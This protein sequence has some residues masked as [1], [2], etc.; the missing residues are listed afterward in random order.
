[1][2]IHLTLYSTLRDLLPRENKGRVI[3]DLPSGSPL[4]ILRQRL[5]LPQNVVFAVNGLIE[6]DET[7]ALQ[8]NDRVAVFRASGGG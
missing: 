6:R 8:D 5:P 7:R 3:M 4:S 2:Q 1:M